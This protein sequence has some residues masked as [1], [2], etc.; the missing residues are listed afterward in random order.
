MR[1]LLRHYAIFWL[2]LIGGLTS[3]S[4]AAL[5]FQ[6]ADHN[7]FEFIVAA[8]LQGAGV[9][10]ALAWAYLFFEQRAQTRQRRI[11]ETV[12]SSVA[13]LRGIATSAVIT[14]TGEIWHK[15]DGHDSYGPNT[16]ERVYQEAR[17]LVLERSHDLADY[18]SDVHSF[19]SLE[20]VFHI[21][22]RVGLNCRQMI[23]TIEQGLIEYGALLR[24]MVDFESRVVIEKQVWDEFRV[25]LESRQIPMPA[26]AIFNMLAIAEL[27]VRLIDVLDSKNYSG[28]PEYEAIRKFNP[29]NVWR[30]DNW[31]SWR[32]PP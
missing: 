13:I 32:R 17:R 22:E 5:L 29:V 11:K 21:S 26:E 23:Q 7:E 9:L 19:G 1:Q 20:W 6:F 12:E 10:L 27:T 24:E 3:G 28:N 25:R 30:G 2:L 15:P 18:R 4:I 16:G 14:T 31:G 8:C